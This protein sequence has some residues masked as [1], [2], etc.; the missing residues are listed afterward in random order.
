MS[1]M[2]LN[3]EEALQHREMKGPVPTTYSLVL[4]S[5][6]Q[7]CLANMLCVASWLLPQQSEFLF[8]YIP[9]KLVHCQGVEKDAMTA[10][11]SNI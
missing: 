3:H 9:S 11:R 4:A 10:H 5:V 8:M 1:S 7:Q 2:L 6:T